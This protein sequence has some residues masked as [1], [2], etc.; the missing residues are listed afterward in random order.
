ML[1]ANSMLR[2]SRKQVRA[3]AARF[4]KGR[5]SKDFSKV[6]ARAFTNELCRLVSTI[7]IQA[8]APTRFFEIDR[9]VQT[10]LP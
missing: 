6:R 5:P 2:W 3:C 4:H 7:H 1:Y 9:R 8:V 10:S